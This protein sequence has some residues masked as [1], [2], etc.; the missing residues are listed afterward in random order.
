[1]R[2]QARRGEEKPCLHPGLP[3]SLPSPRCLCKTA[4]L[5]QA[6]RRGAEE[7]GHLSPPRREDGA[8]RSPPGVGGAAGRGRPRGGR[9]RGAPRK[10]LA[11]AGT[12]QGLVHAP[13]AA[14][15]LQHPQRRHPAA[16]GSAPP[17][18]SPSAAR[19]FRCSFVPTPLAQGLPA[20]WGAANCSLNP[21]TGWSPV[22]EATC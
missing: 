19:P 7:R 21:K 5:G 17:A 8:L 13:D 14:V 12:S 9:G 2:G 11:A 10:A 4:G 18:A 16:H 3:P 20:S 15:Q 1:M 6:L 22:G